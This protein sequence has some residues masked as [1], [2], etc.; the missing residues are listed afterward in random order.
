MRKQRGSEVSALPGL[1]PAAAIRDA[2]GARSRPG[3][4]LDR[5]GTIIVDHGYVGS[6]DRVEFIE[7]APEAIA[8]FN[9]AGIPVA[10]LTNQ[11]GVARG[12][13]GIDDVARV[14]RY[15]ADR[16]AEH[17]AHIDLFLYCP[18]HPGGVVEAF[19]RSSE[20][21]KPRPGMAKAAAAALNLDLTASWVVGDR[22]ED[23]GLAEAVGAP[24]VYL[25]TG[26]CARSGVWSFPGLAAASA[27]ILER[28][29]LRGST[30]DLRP[31]VPPAGTS[32]VKFPAMP[33]RSAASYLAGYVEES[34]WAAS[35]IQPAALDKAAAILLDAY[36]HGAEVFA[37]GNGGSAAISN[38]LQC[39]HMK[40]VRTATDLAPRVVSLS[41][42]VELLTA[43]A[44]DLAYDDVF[45]YQLQSQ[46]R[47]GDVLIAVSSSGRSPNIVRALRW[48]REHGLRTIA[49]T[50][51]DGGE[52]RSAAEVAV[53]VDGTNYGIVE[54]LHQAIMHALAQYIRQ[55]R[56]PADAISSTVF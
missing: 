38:H 25:G 53:H 47:R 46:S 7:G 31:F 5:D 11:A 6:V 2:R 56:I 51:F 22:P 30:A 29:A 33:Y 32:P 45:V 54:D 4:L 15:I 12:L 35:S 39:D 10:V 27:F 20:D 24:A 21:R 44:N 14:H 16:L 19:A 42:N 49:L 9:R 36:A 34:V 55:S 18:Y 48:A 3:I 1:Q 13:Y 52:A 17:G 26:G 50:G 43:I 41:S 23:I 37:C 40:G 28:I 8:S